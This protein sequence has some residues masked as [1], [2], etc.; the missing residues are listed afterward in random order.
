VDVSFWGIS[1]QGQSILYVID[2][3]PGMKGRPIDAVIKKLTESINR[4]SANQTVQV[5]F[6][7][8]RHPNHPIPDFRK[9]SFVGNK[10][11]V[12][13]RAKHFATSSYKPVSQFAGSFAGR[14]DSHNVIIQNAV[15][16]ALKE[17]ANVMYLVAVD[18]SPFDRR[19]QFVALKRMS[20]ANIGNT[21]I[22]CVQMRLL[23]ISTGLDS[24]SALL[25]DL[26][27]QNGGRFVSAR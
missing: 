14:V 12:I 25:K 10:R 9:V 16:T 4:L 15:E 20:Q 8:C 3:S 27:K 23:D 2:G 7:I 19:S 18:K 1:D 22:H 11:D 13:A 17:K 26:A 21:K 5:Q 24:H 6:Y